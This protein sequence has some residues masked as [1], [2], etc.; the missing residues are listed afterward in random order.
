[1]WDQISVVGID[2][3]YIE[4]NTCETDNNSANVFKKYGLTS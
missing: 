4:E 2:Q 3:T 1:M